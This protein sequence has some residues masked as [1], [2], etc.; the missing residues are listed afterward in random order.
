VA[1]AICIRCGNT[2]PAPWKKCAR[3]KLDPTRREDDLVKSVYLSLGRFADAERKKTYKVELEHVGS[4]I[5]QGRDPEYQDSELSRLRAEQKS[6]KGVPL[7]VVL[8]AVI[9][10]FLPG[11]VFL[12]IAYAALYLLRAFRETL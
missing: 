5:E 10:L 4:E 3:C 12:V 6:I 11:V 8:D 7:S 2:K 9:R 1:N